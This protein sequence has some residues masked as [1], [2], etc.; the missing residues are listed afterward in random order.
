MEADIEHLILG[1]LGPQPEGA[2]ATHA[3]VVLVELLHPHPLVH[4]AKPAAVGGH[5]LTK[6]PL[7]RSCSC[8]KGGAQTKR[9]VTDK[10]ASCQVMCHG[11]WL[12]A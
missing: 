4:A 8:W 10:T 7:V 3:A 11:K 9:L 6:L 2:H 5:K 1:N 12:I